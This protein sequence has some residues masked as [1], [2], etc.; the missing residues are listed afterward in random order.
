MPTG[1]GPFSREEVSGFLANY[2]YSTH[3]K[4]MAAPFWPDCESADHS[5]KW[6]D[7][8]A[9]AVRGPNGEVP[10]RPIRVTFHAVHV[11]GQALW[12]MQSAKELAPG[13]KSK[14][15]DRLPGTPKINA[16]WPD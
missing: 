5:L 12:E 14:A 7:V 9:D 8:H 3:P 6:F 13:V 16:P 11:D 15:L 1:P 2:G 4:R 10:E